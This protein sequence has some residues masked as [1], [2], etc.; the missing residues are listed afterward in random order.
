MQSG[1]T[2]KRV[3]Q[4]LNLSTFNDATRRVLRTTRMYT[5]AHDLL[6]SSV[7]LSTVT[8]GIRNYCRQRAFGYFADFSNNRLFVLNLKPLALLTDV[9][10]LMFRNSLT[11]LNESVLIQ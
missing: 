7:I 5:P 1:W 11:H 8:Y 6:R 10:E 2:N 9:C 4:A 3:F